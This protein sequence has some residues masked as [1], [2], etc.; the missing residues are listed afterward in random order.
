MRGFLHRAVDIMQ[1]IGNRNRREKQEDDG[2]HGHNEDE[3]ARP[4]CS[5]AMVERNEDAQADCDG[6]PDEIECSLHPVGEPIC[7]LRFVKVSAGSGWIQN[8]ANLYR[9]K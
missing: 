6:K 4:S 9:Y 8:F 2:S 1:V 3:R 5:L 7:V